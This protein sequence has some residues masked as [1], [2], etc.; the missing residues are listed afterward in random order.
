[1][2]PLVSVELK[3]ERGLLAD[4]ICKN[5]QT[6]AVMVANLLQL[7]K[8]A[9]LEM[10]YGRA[11]VF[12][13]AMDKFSVLIAAH[14]AVATDDGRTQYMHKTVRRWFVKDA[15]LEIFAQARRA[16]RNCIEMHLD[17]MLP[18]IFADLD[19]V[20]ERTGRRKWR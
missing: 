13:I 16:V 4:A 20:R 17:A 15:D 8:R 11:D 19:C 6:G 14:W 2:W 9:G 12:T 1:M 7:K 5:A 10:P 18:M 3:G